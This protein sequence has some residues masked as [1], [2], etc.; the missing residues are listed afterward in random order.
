MPNTFYLHVGP[1]K[2]A[3]TFL[4]KTILPQIAD[5]R[6]H[7]KPTVTFGDSEINFRD[8]FLFS[9]DLW[10]TF[11]KEPFAFL[12]DSISKEQDVLVSDEG[13][14][15]RPASPQPRLD[16]RQK[17]YGPIVKANPKAGGRQD[18]TSFRSHLDALREGAR[19]QGFSQTKVLLTV[20]RQ[21]EMLA[22]LYAQLSRFVRGA[23]QENFERWALHLTN[24]RAGFYL[25]GGQKLSYYLWYESIVEALGE[26]NVLLLP[27]ELLRE[28]TSG[29]LKRWLKFLG[30][31]SA[32]SIANSLSD[33][34][35]KNR[36][37]G[38]DLKWDI[39]PPIRKL[40]LRPSRV[41]KAFG[42]PTSLPARWPDFQRDEEI[43]LTRELSQETLRSYEE[44]NRRLDN[45]GLDLNLKEYGYY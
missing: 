20:R 16:L 21:D 36:R 17:K 38:S 26:T 45:Q 32:V 6:C 8:L 18:H 31:E 44:E 40:N 33:T 9:P 24:D 13:I 43:R 5:I 41:F 19:K 2:T 4:Q 3:S 28:S 35:A 15:R 11:R 39:S 7:T 29:F 10:K 42:L 12:K 37:S 30:V 23:S 14:Y 27:F 22:S 34:R 25:G 1:P